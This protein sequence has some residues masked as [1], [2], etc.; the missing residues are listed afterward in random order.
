MSISNLRWQAAHAS[1]RMAQRGISEEQVYAALA[2]EQ[3]RSP[4][5]GGTVWIHGLTDQGPL[6]VCVSADQTKVITAAWPG[7]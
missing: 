1:E 7:E 4:G 6:N 2:H 5:Q 3:R